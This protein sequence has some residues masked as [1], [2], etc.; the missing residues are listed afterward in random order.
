[1]VNQLVIFQNAKGFG[2]SSDRSTAVY[3]ISAN[4]SN[5][6]HFSKEKKVIFLIFQI[7]TVEILNFR[8]LR[9]TNPSVT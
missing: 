5:L 2:V 3:H 7:N 6:N 1:M 4:L 9:Q 8:L